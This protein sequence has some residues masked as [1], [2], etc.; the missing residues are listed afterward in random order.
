MSDY[1]K[2]LKYKNKYLELKNRRMMGG[3]RRA[4]GG[5]NGFP[6]EDEICFW[7]RQLTEHMLFLFLG[8][9]DCNPKLN[10][11]EAMTI[12]LRFNDCDLSLKKEA[13]ELYT[14]WKNY[15]N[16]KFWG[17]GIEPK[18]DLVVLSPE[19]LELVG[20]INPDE[21]LS[22]I[23]NTTSY[24]RKIIDILGGGNWIGWI[25]P[26]LVMHMQ[27]ETDYFKRK[28]TGPAFT[29]DEEIAFITKHHSEE[30]GTTAHLIDPSPE[31]ETKDAHDKAMNFAN[32]TMP[33]W[34]ES[35]KKILQG[36]DVTEQATLLN[37]SIR[38]SKELVQFTEEG[39]PKIISGEIK[40]VISPVLAKHVER[41]F[42]RFT[43]TLE[44]LKA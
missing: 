18:P 20:K 31:K 38:Y 33:D 14:A 7:G 41:E 27:T 4:R 11:D 10:T 3:G 16:T 37:L 44:A 30:I 9:E 35:D 24:Q 2:Y 19:N 36:M 17:K 39:G 13:F 32:K 12:K 42:K 21:A 5:A 40:S 6:V 34:S 29:P 1:E 25:F 8:M 28:I 43:M 26:S 22:L 15:M 23:E